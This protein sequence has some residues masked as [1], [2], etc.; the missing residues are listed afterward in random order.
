MQRLC[1]LYVCVSL[2]SMVVVYMC[3]CLCVRL[4][5][6]VCLSMALVHSEAEELYQKRVLT[7]TGI[8][9]CTAGGWHRVCGGILQNQVSPGNSSDR[10]KELCTFTH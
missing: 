3:V 4:C 6:C 9:W 2:C 10:Q 1:V 8:C 5:I 7:I